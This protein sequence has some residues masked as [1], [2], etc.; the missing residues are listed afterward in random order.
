MNK[1]YKL[2]LGILLLVLLCGCGGDGGELPAGTS[3]ETE[4]A[5][6]RK[7]PPRRI[8]PQRGRASPSMERSSWG[9]LSGHRN[10]SGAVCRDLAKGGDDLPGVHRDW[11]SNEE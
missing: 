1:R 4:P 6:P 11:V 9:G 10:C 3:P 7:L 8:R 2:F 5:G